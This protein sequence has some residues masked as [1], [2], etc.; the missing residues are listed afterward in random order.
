MREIETR[1]KQLGGRAALFGGLMIAALAFS[2]GV[3]GARSRK[4]VESPA[5]RTE[6]TSVGAAT[7]VMEPRWINRSDQDLRERKVPGHSE[8][9]LQLD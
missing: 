3:V 7:Y 9:D 2:A 8:L 4:P 5:I 1:R 6:T